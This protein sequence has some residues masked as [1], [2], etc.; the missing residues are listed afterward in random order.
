MRDTCQDTAVDTEKDNHAKAHMPGHSSKYT[1]KRTS[2]V[3]ARVDDT[4]VSEMTRCTSIYTHLERRQLPLS[5]E[6]HR[7]SLQCNTTVAVSDR[8][9]RSPG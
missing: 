2:H 4:P 8:V 6:K 7:L 1:Q 5:F 9:S 3:K